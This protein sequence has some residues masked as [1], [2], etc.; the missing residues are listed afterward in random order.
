MNRHWRTIPLLV[1]SVFLVVVISCGTKQSGAEFIT[2]D[3]GGRGGRDG[4]VTGGGDGAT[5]T[6]MFGGDGGTFGSDGAPDSSAPRGCDP[7][8]AAAGGTCQNDTT[9]VIVENPGNVG[10]ATQTQLGTGGTADPSFGWLY[11]YNQVMFARGITSPTMQFAGTA[12][13]DVMVHITAA[14]LDYTG[15][16]APQAG[17]N[18]VSIS[19]NAWTAITIAAGNVQVAATKI[20]GGAVSGPITETWGI[21]Q[22]SMRGT[23]YYET[24]ESAL[25]TMAGGA[26]GVGIM[27]ISPG[28]AQPQVLKS[29]CGN[30]CHTASADGST[31]VAFQNYQ[32]PGGTSAAYDLRT[33]ASQISAAVD[34][35]YMYGGLYPDGSFFMS[36]TNTRLWTGNPSR[37]YD[38]MSGQNI[39]ASGWDGTIT[40]AG[41][42]AFSPDGTKFAFVHEDKDGGHT[43]SVMSFTSST[44]TF[45][46]LVDLTTDPNYVGWPAFT[47]DG[48]FVVYQAG[49][50]SQ[51]E[52]MAMD[53]TGQPFPSQ[54][55]TDYGAQADLYIVNIQSKTATRLDALDGYSSSG[56]YLPASDPDLN[57]APTILPEAVGGYFWVVFTSHRSYGNLLAS[58]A[59]DTQNQGTDDVG[60]L[61]V[62]ALDIP[63]SAGEF[64]TAPSGDPSH[65]AFYLDGQELQADNL[66]GFWV[67]PPCM[68][69]GT[70]CATGDQ[71]CGGYCVTGMCSST[72]PSCSNEFDLCMTAAD[73]C[74]TTDLC[75][76][77][78]CAQPAQ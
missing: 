5:T 39:A 77:G 9:C 52:E 46:N 72:P 69:N 41:T 53:V 33:N 3:A 24:Y 43:L 54:F 12:P 29:G 15:Y 73:C 67:L 68:S 55:E 40:N 1:T 26:G 74:M 38:T 31:L 42:T 50:L 57:F 27:Q 75:I 14:T 45:S 2:G 11:P 16:L 20:A 23:I 35:R 62:A 19:A 63:T 70:G 64:P 17:V 36:V 4:S 34:E 65:P 25:Q 61:W 47:P 6:N 44:H 30:V 21:A 22:G 59:S 7:S 51:Y 13:T 48:N 8:C 58:Q 60:K 78:R 18:G 71:C 10:M 37:L 49:P 32:G 76:N 66:R 56:T 28:A